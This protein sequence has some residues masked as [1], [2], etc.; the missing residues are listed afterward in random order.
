MKYQMTVDGVLVADYYNLE[1]VVD[2]TRVAL[3]DDRFTTVQVAKVNDDGSAYS[4]DGGEDATAQ[5]AAAPAPADAATPAAPVDMY[6]NPV[7]Q[8]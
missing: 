2:H 7:A 6:G 4:A 8:G 5:P 1:K 3:E